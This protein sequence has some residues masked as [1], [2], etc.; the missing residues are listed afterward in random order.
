ML[1]KFNIGFLKLQ[2]DPFRALGES[3]SFGRFMTEP[4]AW[5][6]WSAFS[7]NRY[8]EEV[9]KFSKPGSVAQKKAYFEAHYKRKA[10][11]RAAALLETVNAVTS[12][13][14]ESVIDKNSED[15]SPD[16]CLVKGENH[17]DEQLEK[18]DPVEVVYSANMSG[19]NSSAERNELDFAK[20][21][22]EEV[23]TQEGIDLENSNR[24]EISNQFVNKEDHHSIIVANVEEKIP[25]HGLDTTHTEGED[26]CFENS[27]KAKISNQ[28]VN[29]KD[30]HNIVANIEEKILNKVKFL[31]LFS[32][33]LLHVFFFFP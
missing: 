11:E 26:I 13:V 15:S 10:A 31:A 25:N 33:F 18:D 12:N 1:R 14:S 6:K 30:H 32:L 17:M 5:E 29:G 4:L 28:F 23:V 21:E 19:C 22:V 2:E 24:V 8:L 27:N 7:H 20:V 9:E 3:I 16:P